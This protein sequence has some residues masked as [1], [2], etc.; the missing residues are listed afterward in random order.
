MHAKRQHFVPQFYLKN[1]AKANGDLWICRRRSEAK[2][3]AVFKSSAR[4]ICVENNLYE[5][6]SRNA[7][8]QKFIE[9]GAIEAAL[10][11]MEST[12]ALSIKH[13]TEYDPDKPDTSSES[14]W[15]HL[16]VVIV[17]TA[18]LIVRN[19]K[20]IKTRRKLA[21]SLTRDLLSRGFFSPND[22]FELGKIDY[23]SDL[24]GIVELSIQHAEL[25]NFNDRSSTMKLVEGF[26][27][28]S[29]I[30][31]RAP[32]NASFITSSFP[33]TASWT[34]EEA[35]NPDWLYLPFSATSALIFHEERQQNFFFRR[36][37]A[38]EVDKLNVYS[39]EMNALWDTA[40]SGSKTALETCLHSMS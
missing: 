28:M 20:W 39:L 38:E 16:S 40:I 37:S 22:L 23:S 17:F 31:L 21:E 27:K 33:V 24:Q 11:R 12:F 10:S 25:L 15:E 13:L 34:D 7:P 30:L 35:E 14:P 1:F 26:N 2:S 18:N 8:E 32:D 6:P 4:K 19:P 5:I 36:I 3:P 29:V 9:W